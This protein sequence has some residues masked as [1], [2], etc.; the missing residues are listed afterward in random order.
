MH[1]ISFVHNC[2]FFDIETVRK[3]KSFEELKD[4]E[5]QIA[6]IWLDKCQ[7]NENYKNEPELMYEKYASLYP[8]YS[9]I[10]CIS[11]GYYDSVTSKW[12]IEHLND[13]QI[14]E[15]ELLFE[16]GKLCNTKFHKSILAGY[17]IRRFDIPFV[18][19]RMLVNNILPPTQFDS[20]EKKPWE[21]INLD[22]YKVW[23]DYNTLNGMSN[24]DLVCHIMGVPSPKQGEVKG[25]SVGEYYYNGKIQEITEY[26]KKD[27]QASIKLALSLSTEKLEEPTWN[28]IYRG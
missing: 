7:H 10:V 28:S 25:D 20:S 6:E 9:K 5:P 21:I 22:L 26:C 8:E 1:N 16:F 3:Y 17:N 14:T 19:R 23:S 15:K 18:Y 27:V 4:N 13:E 24:F 2:L 12:K 11:Y